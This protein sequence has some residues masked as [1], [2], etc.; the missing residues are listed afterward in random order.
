MKKILK[1]AVLEMILFALAGAAFAA[2]GQT[3]SP[4][5]GECGRKCKGEFTITNN[6]LAPLAVT[7]Q[8]FSFRLIGHPGTAF[9]AR[10][11]Q[12]SRFALANPA[13]AYRSKARIRFPTPSNAPQRPAQSRLS[14]AW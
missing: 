9:S 13:P 14:P 4:V 11:I 2:Y 3:V 1:V 5:I 12:R 6:G 8:P 10:W 7:V